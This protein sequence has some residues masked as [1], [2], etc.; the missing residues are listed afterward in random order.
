MVSGQSA[1]R[2][3]LAAIYITVPDSAIIA[4]IA[5]LGRVGIFAEPA[6]STAYAGLEAAVQM[7]EIGADDEV[8]VMNTGSGLKDVRAAM[9][10]VKEAEIIEPSMKALKKIL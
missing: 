5:K 8:L 7:G 3:R 9:M 6:G 1:R 10:A 4:A 2:A